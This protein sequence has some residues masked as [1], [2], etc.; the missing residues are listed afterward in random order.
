MAAHALKSWQRGEREQL[1]AALV[2]QLIGNGTVPGRL[3]HGLWEW[4]PCDTQKKG[5]YSFVIGF[6]RPVLGQALCVP[7]WHRMGLCFHWHWLGDICA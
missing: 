6:A 3:G 2:S 7:S 5:S 1:H 4:E